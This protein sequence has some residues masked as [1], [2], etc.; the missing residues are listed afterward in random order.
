M[1]RLLRLTAF[2]LLACWLPATSHCALEAAGLL[3]TALTC[4]DDDACADQGQC[5][6]DACEQVEGMPYKQSVTLLTIAAPAECTHPFL[7]YLPVVS[8]GILIATAR[9]EAGRGQEPQDW[10]VCWTF[11]HRA[12]PPSRAPSNRA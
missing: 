11:T 6:A 7:A 12:A 8:P 4:P 1:S 9:P 5:G 10:L 2:V 3:P